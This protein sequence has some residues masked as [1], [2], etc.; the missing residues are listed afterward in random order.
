MEHL[1][2]D[3]II[4]Y[5]EEEARVID[6]AIRWELIMI[7]KKFHAIEEELLRGNRDTMRV[8]DPLFDI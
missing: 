5:F 8:L 7:Y 2:V 3:V 1:I 6:D 4:T